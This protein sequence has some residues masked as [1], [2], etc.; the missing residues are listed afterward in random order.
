VALDVNLSEIKVEILYPSIITTDGESG[1]EFILRHLKTSSETILN[2]A[3]IPSVEIYPNPASTHF[4]LNLMND[5][6]KK[7]EI[8]SLSGRIL[9]S[10]SNPDQTKP[11]PIS[12]L[13]T[14]VYLVKII[15]IKTETLRKLVI[16]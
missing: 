4:F 13:E 7:V 10:K 5:E 9:S 8:L 16:K 11:I 1:N 15:G 6:I 3:D 12:W 14:G 2:V